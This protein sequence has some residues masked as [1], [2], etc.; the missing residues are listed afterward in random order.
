MSIKELTLTEIN[1]TS[2]AGGLRRFV[3]PDPIPCPY[4]LPSPPTEFVKPPIGYPIDPPP[5][6][7]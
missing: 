7:I 4:P 1:S 6:I 5:D 2:V 3:L